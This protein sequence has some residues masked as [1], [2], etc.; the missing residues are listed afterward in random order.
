[1]VRGSSITSTIMCIATQSG[2]RIRKT[3]TSKRSVFLFCNLKKKKMGGNSISFLL[4]ITHT[5]TKKSWLDFKASG[6]RTLR[7]PAV[8][9]YFFL[10]LFHLDFLITIWRPKPTRSTFCLTVGSS[11][12]KLESRECG[13]SSE[14]HYLVPYL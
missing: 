1:M 13:G 14:Y 6:A 4:P 10:L 12:R 9:R 7:C 2:W 8:H 11:R 3:K 5:H